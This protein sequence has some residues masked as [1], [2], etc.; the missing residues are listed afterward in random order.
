MKESSSSI[1]KKN[2][3]KLLLGTISEKEIMELQDWLEDP[4]N[5]KILEAYVRDYHDLN[6]A[7]LKNNLDEAY[8]KVNNRIDDKTK[9]IKRLFPDWMKYAAAVI[10]LMALG[11]IYQQGF[12]ST[13]EQYVLV[14][15]EDTITLE[16][17]NGIVQSIDVS[18]NKEYRDRE[19]NVVYVQNQGL[20]RY[21]KV[22]ENEVLVYN[23]LL[24]PN[25]KTFQ[26]ELSDGTRVQLNAGSSLKYPV[27]FLEEGPRKV[28][29]TGNAYFDV[30]KNTANPF[31]VN[32]DE[33]DVKV[34]GTEFNISA[35]E[36]DENIDVV[37]VEGAVNMAGKNQS[38]DLVELVPGQKGS[39]DPKS[40]DVLVEEVDTSLYTSWRQ[41]SLVYRE[42]TFNKILKKLERHYNIEIVNNNVELGEEVFNARFD[43]MEIEEVL[44]YFKDIHDID[45]TVENNKVT[46][47]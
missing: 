39:F 44:G 17:N 32:V 29:L 36:E 1:M 37:L 21:S 15:K 19:G 13:E 2:I 16:L 6:L 10:V 23:T 9:P 25:G 11:L 27:N 42:L 43:R 4:N 30:T 7:T 47:N 46:I 8:S 5:Q 18:G 26:V 20:I 28:F 31:V 22:T 3:T 35:Y 33:L 40:K 24:V 41:G 34:L 14:P 45:F 38:Q 12:F